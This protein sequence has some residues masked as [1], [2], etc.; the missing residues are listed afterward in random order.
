VLAGGGV[1]AFL[2]LILVAAP[3]ADDDNSYVG[4]LGGG[5]G[6]G[7][8]RLVVGPTLAAFGVGDFAG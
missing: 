2:K 4:C 3:G 1:Q 5:D 6:C 7:E 8:A